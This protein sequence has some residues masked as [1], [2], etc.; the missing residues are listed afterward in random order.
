MCYQGCRQVPG[1]GNFL[2]VPTPKAQPFLCQ[3][4]EPPK[5]LT[6][7]SHLPYPSN[8]QLP[9]TAE[10]IWL[11]WHLS[12]VKIACHLVSGHHAIST[13]GHPRWQPRARRALW[14]AFAEG[15]THSWSG[16][17]ADCQ[18]PKGEGP[19]GKTR[20]PERGTGPLCPSQAGYG[21]GRE[22]MHLDA[23]SS[24]A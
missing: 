7:G 23:G 13:D 17:R 3:A 22:K 1:M 4:P 21:R 2:G 10:N 8:A 19:E 18:A 6:S 12:G 11:A 16:H 20:G 15:R 24:R 9:C 5:K 14:K